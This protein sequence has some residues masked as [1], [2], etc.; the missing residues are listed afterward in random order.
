MKENVTNLR[1]INYNITKTTQFITQC[2]VVQKEMRKINLENMF[3]KDFA[4]D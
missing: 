2:I 3:P 4:F 1:A